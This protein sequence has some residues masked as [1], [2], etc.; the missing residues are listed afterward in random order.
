[1]T[2]ED[3]MEDEAFETLE[4]GVLRSAF[5]ASLNSNFTK[6]EERFERIVFD[7]VAYGVTADGAT[8]DAPALNALIAAV[9]SGNDAGSLGETP[10]IRLPMGTIKIASPIVLY[11]GIKI[12]GHGIASKISPTAGFA[13]AGLFYLKPG[14]ASW[15]QDVEIVNVSTDGTHTT[16]TDEYSI[17]D[18]TGVASSNEITAIGHDFVA[19]Q[20]VW[21]KTNT[22]S[23]GSGLTTGTAYYVRDI[24]GNTFKLAASSG[25]AAI[26]FTTNITAA[27]IGTFPVTVQRCRFKTM[28]IESAN[29]IVLRNYCQATTFEDIYANGAT[30]KML[31][32]NGNWN[33][34]RRINK[35]GSTGT[36]SDPYIKIEHIFDGNRS[37][38][39]LIDGINIEGSGSANKTPFYFHGVDNLYIQNMWCELQG[40]PGSVTDGYV[41]RFEDS[42]NVIIRG[43]P[44][45]QMPIADAKIKVDTTL[46]LYIE[47]LYLDPTAATIYEIFEIDSD[48]NVTLGTLVSRG[49]DSAIKCEESTNLR[50]QRIFSKNNSLTVGTTQFTETLYTG[51]NLLANGSF[52]NER[53]GWTIDSG[54]TVTTSLVDSGVTLGKA[55]QCTISPAGNFNIYQNVVFTAEH[56]GKPFTFTGAVKTTTVAG[57]IT[58]FINGAGILLETNSVNFAREDD[59]T[60]ISQT[61]VPQSAGTCAIGVYCWSVTLAQ[62]D[63]FSV[64]PG[65]IGTLASSSFK[66]LEVNSRSITVGSAIPTSGQGT[67]RVGDVRHNSE[68]SADEYAGWVC[69]VAGDPGTWVGFGTLSAVKKIYGTAAGKQIE[70]NA[71]SDPIFKVWNEATNLGYQ[72]YHLGGVNYIDTDAYQIRNRQTAAVIESWSSAAGRKINGGVSTAAFRAGEDTV[73]AVELSPSDASRIGYLAWY[74]IGVRHGF[75]GY[76]TG[77]GITLTLEQGGPFSIVGGNFKPTLPTSNP[78]PGILWNDGNT[79]K[80]G[81]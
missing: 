59:W 35:E 39:N 5:R 58:P 45:I 66:S 2:Y 37:D 17:F 64:V 43:T 50:I 32:F 42:F 4:N 33:V 41:M 27:S 71:T 52:E 61:F 62:V 49:N 14:T 57:Y 53:H 26:D 9:K 25:G 65:T 36:S 72:I 44:S 3:V 38:G 47:Q 1:M 8:D 77:T 80:V 75:I 78:G 73:G 18:A 21:F 51:S 30:N 34:L 69:T 7:A 23:G 74:K 16:L 79:V 67:W 54:G 19:N 29:G 70:I 24:S 56:V 13:G 28:F 12:E 76:D 81:T 60:V 22:L 15:I 20:K 6:V 68:P 31:H 11:S 46:N 48:S 10:I 55:M 63:E 40:T